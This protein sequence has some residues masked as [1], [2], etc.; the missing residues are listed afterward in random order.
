[1]SVNIDRQNWSKLSNYFARDHT[2]DSSHTFIR[3]KMAIKQFAESL[4]MNS[5]PPWNHSELFINLFVEKQKIIVIR[6]QSARCSMRTAFNIIFIRGSFRLSSMWC[7]CQHRH[8]KNRQLI[9]FALIFGRTA[10]AFFANL[11]T[12]FWYY[13]W[14][15]W[16][17][18]WA[19]DVVQREGTMLRQPNI[20]N[21]IRKLKTKKQKTNRKLEAL[22]SRR[23]RKKK[24]RNW[25]AR[26]RSTRAHCV[27]CCIK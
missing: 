5:T 17:D 3:I 23:W 18:C 10:T 1:M 9:C 14:C 19:V 15:R 21:R 24:W 20:V 22:N 25:D 13:S 12:H 11:H 4:L 7:S 16:V 6:E 2:R 27:H 26:P 8:H